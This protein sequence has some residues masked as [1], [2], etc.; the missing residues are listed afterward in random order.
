MGGAVAAVACQRFFDF[1]H[2][3]PCHYGTF[4]IIEQTP[5]KFVKGMEGSRTAVEVPGVGVTLTC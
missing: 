3:I 4:P 2:A 5:D 1:K